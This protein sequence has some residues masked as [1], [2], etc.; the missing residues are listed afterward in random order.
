M[1]LENDVVM[2]VKDFLFYH[3]KT[4]FTEKKGVWKER[5]TAGVSGG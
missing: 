3:V 1:V 2:L 5:V 4:E